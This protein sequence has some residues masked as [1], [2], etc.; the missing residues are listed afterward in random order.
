MI[1][2]RMRVWI[3]R[4]KED[5]ARLAEALRAQGI[6]VLIEPLIRIVFADGP[7]LAL[8]GVQALLATSANGV[9]AFARRNQ[10]RHV[11]VLAVGDASARA[12]W[13]EGFAAVESASGDVAALAGLVRLRLDPAR[14]PLLHI[15]GTDVA[16]DLAGA[17]AEAGFE[18]RREVLYTARAAQRLSDGLAA[19]IRQGAVHAVLV[20]SPRTGKTL[21]RLVQAA[22]LAAEARRLICFCLSPAVGTAV[23]PLPWREAMVARQPSQ[24]AL[25]ADVVAAAARLPKEGAPNSL[26]SNSAFT[27]TLRQSS[28]GRRP[29]DGGMSSDTDKDQIAAD[30]TPVAIA[31]SSLPPEP[32][33]GDRRRAK[34]YDSSAMTTPPASAGPGEPVAGAP[35]TEPVPTRPASEAAA[36]EPPVAPPTPDWLAAEHPSPAEPPAPQSS[37]P[38]SR[39]WTRA[40]A[41]EDDELAGAATARHSDDEAAPPRAGGAPRRSRVLLWALVA[42]ALL[43]GAGALA[44]RDYIEPRLRQLVDAPPP[45]DLQGEFNAAFEDLEARQVRL[46]QQLEGLAPRV[47]AIERTLAQLR[48][49]V[50]KFS[51]SEQSAPEQGIQAEVVKQLGDRLALLETQAGAASGLAQQVRSLEASTEA[52]H[53]T[54]SKLATAVL[55]VGQL[56]QTVG[57]GG[58]FVRQLAAVR[59]L[60]G[61]DPDIA[62]AAAELEPFAAT[63]VR[64]LAALQAEFPMIA[65]AVVRASP[66]TAGDSWTE[67]VV[68]QLAS[69]VVVRRLGSGAVAA[70]GV[71]GI[72]AQ[73]DTALQGGDLQAAVTALE[74][75][76]GAPAEAATEWLRDARARLTADRALATLQQ[77]A[78]ARLSTARG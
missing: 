63:G 37:S 53:D 18:Y 34:I 20:F 36:T 64:T 21:V 54:A 32:S 49:S 45:V 25:I 26:S 72:V 8:A 27:A 46:R 47:D 70:G 11:L 77:L 51:T 56:A 43:A 48:A 15:A 6:Q 68:D 35:P 16:G 30:A 29:K 31:E 40:A 75:L 44:Y 50:D 55:A 2:R 57:D 52:A 12:A 60:G 17:L 28:I 71:D 61:N 1:D 76:D 73:A 67:R 23:A 69:L 7:P 13:E 58:A 19:D 78:I 9:R 74:R 3:T 41:G 59:A 38:T 33:A 66:A 5:A 10:Q 14:G 24:A 22:G 65:N 39:P 4:P 42:L 62:Q